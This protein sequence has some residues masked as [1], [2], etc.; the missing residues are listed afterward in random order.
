MPKVALMSGFE[1]RVGVMKAL[2]VGGLVER[3]SR[4]RE[5]CRQ[6]AGGKIGGAYALVERSC[7]PENL[8]VHF[9]QIYH[10]HGLGEVVS[11]HF[12]RRFQVGVS[13]NEH[14]A[15]PFSAP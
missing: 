9:L 11:H 7:A 10:A 15:V 12:N 13:R 14:R 6:L 8:A 2:P 4:V 5:G 1:K 3:S